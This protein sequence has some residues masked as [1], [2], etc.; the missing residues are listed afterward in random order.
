[1]TIKKFHV[2]STYTSAPGST[3]NLLQQY[4]SPKPCVRVCTSWN[5]ATIDQYVELFLNVNNIEKVNM[6]VIKSLHPQQKSVKN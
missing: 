5:Y 4:H 2:S 1:M 3:V 6:Q